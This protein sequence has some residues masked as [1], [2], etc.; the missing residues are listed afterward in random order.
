MKSVVW[1]FTHTTKDLKDR[2]FA[3]R[4]FIKKEPVFPF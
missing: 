3:I 4:F 1:Y 2:I